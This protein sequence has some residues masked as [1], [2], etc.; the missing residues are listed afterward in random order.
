[1]WE[2]NAS[3]SPGPQNKLLSELASDKLHRLGFEVMLSTEIPCNDGGIAYG[4]VIDYLYRQERQH[5]E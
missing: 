5:H 4:Q 2:K 1:M 3:P